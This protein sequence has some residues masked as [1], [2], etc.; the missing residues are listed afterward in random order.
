MLDVMSV[1]VAIWETVCFSFSGEDIIIISNQLTTDK[2]SKYSTESSLVPMISHATAIVTLPREV[3]DGFKQN[4]LFLMNEH[5]KQKKYWFIYI[6][7]NIRMPMKQ[8][9]VDWKT[10]FCQMYKHYLI[11]Q[12]LVVFHA[13]AWV[14]KTLWACTRLSYFPYNLGNP[15]V[16]FTVGSPIFNNRNYGY[17]NHGFPTI[18][19]SRS[20]IWN[21]AY[22]AWNVRL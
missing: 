16:G 13:P 12:F 20:Y 1:L 21:H 15:W 18:D 9:E 19:H 14:K 8:C 22:T 17:C 7:F 11:L 3:C 10:R 5:L 4:I 2:I 6:K